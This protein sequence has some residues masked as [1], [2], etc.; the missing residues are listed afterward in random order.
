M[1]VNESRSQNRELD[2]GMTD[3]KY[4][5]LATNER[6]GVIDPAT[7]ANR[8]HLFGEFFGAAEAPRKVKPDG[9]VA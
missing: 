8:A 1:A 4:K 6:G 9:T 2:E 5:K 7:A 3:G